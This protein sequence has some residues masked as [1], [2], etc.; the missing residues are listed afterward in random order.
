VLLPVGA[1]I[2]HQARYLL[3]FGDRAGAELHDQGHAYLAA[4]STPLPLLVAVAFGLF[5]S[6]VA[7]A[8]RT[9]AAP[10]R[11]AGLLRTWLTAT[12]ML[13][14]VYV[15]QEALEGL[16]ASGHPEGLV[17]IFGSGG[18]IALPVAIGVG[19]VIA[20]ALRLEAAVLKW[21][22]RR[23]RAAVA[24]TRPAPST[25]RRRRYGQRHRRP[26]PLAALGAGRAPPPRLAAYI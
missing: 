5:L 12:L 17:G 19:A 23:S 16:L 3:A 14:T 4:L 1:Y 26:A 22:V 15:A 18:W 20:A 6:R 25:R 9:G 8:C 11:S 10:E 24:P 2:V 21:A 7:R 13:I